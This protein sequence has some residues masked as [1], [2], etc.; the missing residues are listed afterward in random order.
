M[1]E[2]SRLPFKGKTENGYA[3]GNKLFAQHNLHREG[4]GW[5]TVVQ[6]RTCFPFAQIVAWTK[7]RIVICLSASGEVLHIYWS[8]PEKSERQAFG[9]SA[10]W[11]N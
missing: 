9:W 7:M 3:W 5:V 6:L 4:N 1:T 2:L 11:L 10:P 8:S